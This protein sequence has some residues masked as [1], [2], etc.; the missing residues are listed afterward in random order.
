M[1]HDVDGSTSLCF[2][3]E[4]LAKNQNP[5]DASPMIKIPCLCAIVNPDEPDIKN[6]PVRALNIYRKRSQRFRSPKQR[7]LFLSCNQNYQN[8]IRASTI[9]HWMRMLI[10]DV[11]LYWTRGGRGESTP[12]VLALRRPRVHEIR[13][14]AATLALK[15]VSI[16]QVLKAA[17]WSSE[18][19]F[20]HFV[21]EGCF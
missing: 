8:D 17:F 2:L 5:E 18:D 19:I 20:E 13:A 9:S 11:Y 7:A 1:S 6:C 4:F 16:Q 12:G 15:S 14:W 3:P 10:V 21:L